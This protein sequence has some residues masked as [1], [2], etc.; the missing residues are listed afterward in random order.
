[1]T[2]YAR[3]HP[4]Q[5]IVYYHRADHLG[6]MRRL[7]IDF[8]DTTLAL[9]VS[10]IWTFIVIAFLD[11]A[12]AALVSLIGWTIIWFLYFV[13]LKG[14]RFRTLGY[15]ITGARIVNLRGER[16]GYLALTARLAFAM[17]GPANFLIDLLWIS[18]DPGHQAL[19]DKFAHTYV[20]R[21]DAVPAGTGRIVYPTYMAFGWTLMF[22]EVAPDA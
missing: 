10:L 19:R 15:V 11:D 2:C 18:S 8:V 22:A 7:V 3:S 1:M 9:I 12:L 20:I 13:A 4:V 17:L 21:N 6:V 16:P 14:S 5:P